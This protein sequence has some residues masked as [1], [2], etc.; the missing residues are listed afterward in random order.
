[1]SIISRLNDVGL[2]AQLSATDELDEH[3]DSGVRTVYCGFDP[4]AD[5]LHIGNLVPLL[6]LRR[7]QLAGHRPLLLVGGATGMIGDPGGRDAERELQSFEA[8]ER[9]L[10]GIRQ[11]AEQFLDFDCGETS[12]VVVNNMDWTRGLTVVDYL[13]DIGKHFSVNAMIQKESVRRRIEDDTQGISYTE[14]SYMILQSYDYAVLH[15]DYGCTIQMGGSDQWGNITAGIDLIRRMGGEQ[16][17]AVTYP[18]ITKADGTKFGKSSGGAIWLDPEMTSPLSFYQFWRNTADADVMK[19]LRIFTF[20]EEKRLD[21]LQASQEADPGKREAQIALAQEVTK[22]VHGDEGM[23]AA[24]RITSAVFSNRLTELSADD[25]GQL[26]QDG[27]ET[28]HVSGEAQLV[29]VLVESGLAVTPR[30][31]VTIGQARKLIQ[32]NGV[33]VN[34]DK[35]NDIEMTLNVSDALHGKYF[36]VQKGKK[37]HHLVVMGD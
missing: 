17:Y 18:L 6:A 21:E 33:S 13:R 2:I 30:G 9:Q 29:D 24:E 10:A 16:T 32:G 20:L 5:S 23:E 22:L 4:T 8:V 11:Q 14:F 31:E 15:R 36:I 37:N 26:A 28:T 34:G 12:A 27:M 25:L 1:M 7:F 3:L 19:Y 35:A